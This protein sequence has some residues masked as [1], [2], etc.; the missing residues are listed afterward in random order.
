MRIYLD[1]DTVET[2]LVRLLRR[3]GHDTELPADAGLVGAADVIHLRHAIRN[4]RILLS[5]NFRDFENLHYL[6]SDAGG[7]HRG[8]FLIRK[9]NDPRRDMTPRGVV[10]AIARLLAAGLPIEN[11]FHVLNHWR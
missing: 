5:H 6:I 1:D 8:I 10:N 7:R 3:A 4:D 11:G 2:L 9:D